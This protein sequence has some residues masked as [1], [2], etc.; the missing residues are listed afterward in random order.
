M[1]EFVNMHC[2]YQYAK[3]ETVEDLE[4]FDYI[5]NNVMEGNYTFRLNDIILLCELQ[6][7][8]YPYM[9]PHHES[10]IMDMVFSIV[11]EYGINVAFP[12]LLKGLEEVIGVKRHLVGMYL[13]MMLSSYSE[14][15]VLQFAHM[16]KSCSN[17]FKTKVKQLVIESINLN[18]KRYEIK[19]NII[20]ENM[21]A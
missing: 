10:K 13:R 16:L 6:I 19:G 7:Q 3:N 14:E 8:N 17:D 20:L 18:S 11:N 2:L 5:Y 15:M 21:E 9:E 12:E 1:R 4:N